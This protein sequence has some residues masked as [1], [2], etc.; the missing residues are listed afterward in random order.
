MC[1]GALQGMTSGDDALLG[2]TLTRPGTIAGS[3]ALACGMVGAEAA[4]S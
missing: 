2:D 1:G 4:V 3:D